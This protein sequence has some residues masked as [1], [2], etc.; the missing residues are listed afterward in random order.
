MVGLHGCNLPRLEVTLGCGLVILGP[1]HPI[2]VGHLMIVPDGYHRCRGRQCL[3]IGIRAVHGVA[4][5]VVLQRHDLVRWLE[6]GACDPVELRVHIAAI[7]IDEVAKVQPEVQLFRGCSG[8][9]GEA[10]PLPI[11]AAEDSVPQALQGGALCRRQP[12][13]TQRRDSRAAGKAERI[14]DTRSQGGDLDL[15]SEISLLFGRGLACHIPRL[16]AFFGPHLPAHRQLADRAR[17]PGSHSCPQNHGVS[18]RI[19]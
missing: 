15:D 4:C 1:M 8:V 17:V 14:V 16:A 7:L 9:R 2:V 18:E 5:P 13:A 12:E 19:P 10:P 6:P 11:R 3:Q